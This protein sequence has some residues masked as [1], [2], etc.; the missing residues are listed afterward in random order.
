[1]SGCFSLDML[2]DSLWWPTRRQHWQ[3]N[4][5]TFPSLH[6]PLELSILPAG[7]PSTFL[8][9]LPLIER[10]NSGTWKPLIPGDVILRQTG[11]ANSNQLAGIIFHRKV[12]FWTTT[13][14]KLGNYFSPLMTHSFRGE[15]SFSETKKW[16]R[17]R[18]VKIGELETPSFRL[19]KWGWTRRLR[20]T[21]AM[22]RKKYRFTNSAAFMDLLLCTV[23]WYIMP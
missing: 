15:N 22:V 14:R 1:M 2:R 23:M 18:S 7:F 5:S 16:H 6:F 17:N 11:V 3:R 21:I 8:D 20:K 10:H 4:C 19:C 12:I 13:F 9:N